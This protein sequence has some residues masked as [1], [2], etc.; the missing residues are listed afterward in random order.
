MLLFN[1]IR[2]IFCAND[3]T[4]TVETE[5]HILVVSEQLKSII[6]QYTREKKDFVIFAL[7]S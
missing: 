6:N 2:Y 7:A 4:M 5:L 1:K 3:M